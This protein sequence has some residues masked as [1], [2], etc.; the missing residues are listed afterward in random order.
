MQAFR[1]T[2]CRCPVIFFI[3][4]LD[5]HPPETWGYSIFSKRRTLLMSEFLP[6]QS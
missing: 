2:E 1:Q 5:E 3:F 4:N 6:R